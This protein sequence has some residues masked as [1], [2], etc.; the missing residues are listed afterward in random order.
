[1]DFNL[2]LSDEEYQGR[3]AGKHTEPYIYELKSDNQ[4]LLYFGSRHSRNPKDLQWELLEKQWKQFLNGSNGK[5]VILFEGNKFPE[6]EGNYENIIMQFGESG[7]LLFLAKDS[8]TS[9]AWPDPLFSEEASFLSEK[10]D[11]DLVAYFVFVRSASSWLRSGTMGTFDEVLQKAAKM[12]AARVTGA[13]EDVSI[14]SAIHKK[15][16]GKPLSQD[17][18]EII[19]RASPPVYHDSI[20]NDIA[21]ADSRFRNERVVITAEKY[22][23]EGYS[24]FMLFGSAHAVIQEPAL[25]AMVEG[26]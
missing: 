21:R 8:D 5:R 4:A 17:Q 25:R 23:K 3:F 16:F 18:R 26:K 15:I 9:Y 7:A 24:I 13:P 19:Y 6:P 10:F 11:P 20:I 22:W 14:Y 1:M 12:T 2:L